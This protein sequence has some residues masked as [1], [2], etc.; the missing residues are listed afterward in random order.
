MRRGD[1]L[2]VAEKRRIGWKR[3]GREYVQGGGRYRSCVYRRNKLRFVDQASTRGIDYPHAFFYFGKCLLS[4]NAPGI[5]GNRRVNSE[6]I[7]S[8]Q[9]VVERT[10]FD[11]EI[12]GVF[13]RHEGVECNHL[14]PKAAC[15]L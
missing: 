14:H 6:K 15:D 7:S 3:L 8:L 5:V 4:E 10:G 11:T 2:R 12:L 13:G 9:Y 1:Y